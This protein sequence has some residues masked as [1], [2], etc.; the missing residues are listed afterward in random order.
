MKKNIVI[1]LAILFLSFNCAFAQFEYKQIGTETGTD[2]FFSSGYRE[3]REDTDWGVMPLLPGSH[4]YEYDY[5]AVP[6]GSGLL[7]LAGMGIAYGIRRR[8]SN[9]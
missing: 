4:G 1:S 5:S 2:G 6:A 8:K 3:Y 9:K 7:L